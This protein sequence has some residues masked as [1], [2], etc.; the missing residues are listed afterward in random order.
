MMYT[1]A[2]SVNDFKSNSRG[3]CLACNQTHSIQ[4]VILSLFDWCIVKN[5]VLI[6]TNDAAFLPSGN[7]A[8]ELILAPRGAERAMMSSAP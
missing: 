4:I 6:I 5:I 2:M 8:V 1:A 3:N 7:P